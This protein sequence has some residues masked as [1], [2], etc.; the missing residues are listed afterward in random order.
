MY[1]TGEFP[2]LIQHE[3]YV[4]NKGERITTLENYVE[5][6]IKKVK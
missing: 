6:Q 1:K 2:E 4:T 5:S 3:T